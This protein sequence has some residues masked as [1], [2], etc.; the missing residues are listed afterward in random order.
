ML[1]SLPRTL[2]KL[3]GAALLLAGLAGCVTSPPVVVDNTAP[4]AGPAAAT[5]GS[6]FTT[7]I[8]AAPL[9]PRDRLN[10]RVMREPDLS[11]EEV[12]VGEDG[13][14]DMP[15]I[16]RVK[17][18]G[19]TT[20]EISEDIRQ[21]LAADYLVNPRVAVN[22]VDYASHTVAVEGAVAQPG[23]YQFQP[24]TTLVGALA[25]ARGPSRVARLNQ[26]AIFRQEAGQRSV[27]VFDLRQV[28]SGQMVDPELHP[29]DRVLV[30]YNGM[31]QA[32]LD[33]LAAAPLLAIFTNY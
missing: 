12:R 22:V 1:S 2:I 27:A 29:G 26:V 25:L 10:V 21:R 15:Q 8:A 9:R 17:A 13:F 18:E 32:W 20:A 33:I 7:E 14:F 3:G 5:P 16:G 28:R 19:R 4:Q 31:K 30:G 11:L 23:I 24:N 6:G